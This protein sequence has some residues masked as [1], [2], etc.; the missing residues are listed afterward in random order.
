M[1]GGTGVRISEPVYRRLPDDRRGR[2]QKQ[3]PPATYT[4]CG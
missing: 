3:K 2:W 4:F 1:G